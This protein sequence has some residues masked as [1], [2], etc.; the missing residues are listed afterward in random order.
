MKVLIVGKNG[1]L[2]QE[3]QNEAKK[4]GY[5][6]F[7][8]GSSELNVTDS[9][10]IEA[11][12][13]EAKPDLFI[14]ASAYNLVQEAEDNLKEA[15]ELNCFAVYEMAR[16]CKQNNATFVTY[17]TDYVFDG[18]KGAPNEE[19]DATSPLQAYGMSKASGEI[20]ARLANPESIIIRT[21]AVY[22]GKTGSPSKGT[23]IV[24]SLLKALRE[25]PFLE[26]VS[27]Q[28]VN[29]TYSKDLSKATFDLIDKK[30]QPGI[31]HLAS[32]GVCNWVEFARELSTITGI[33]KEIREVKL[34]QFPSKVKKPVFSA[35]SNTKAKTLGVTLP[36]WQRALSEYLSDFDL[37]KE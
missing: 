35:L 15:F 27:D 10:Q 4:R 25:K 23:N 20:A 33:N 7:A 13:N 9:G 2:G 16:I 11:K 3:L 28:Y 21:C 37:I 19:T 8:Y 30:A 24:L 12:V 34:D 22:G 29:P 6:I 1:Q 36:S 18:K 17:S 31:Y 32:E 14:N 5:E 26:A